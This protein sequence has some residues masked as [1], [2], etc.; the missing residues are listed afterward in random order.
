MING[1]TILMAVTLSGVFLMTNRAVAQ[2]LTKWE[3]LSANEEQETAKFVQLL[4]GQ[5]EHDYV[6]KDKIV[7]RNAHPRGIAC[8]AATFTIA[9]PNDSPHLGVFK[10]PG[11]TY[12]AIIRFSSTLGPAGDHVGDAR[13]MSIKLFDV[14]GTKLLTDQPHANTQ[15]FTQIDTPAFF[16]VNTHDFAGV[17]RLKSEPKSIVSFLLESPIVH[18]LELKQLHDLT[19][20]NANNGKS[21]A[22]TTFFSQVPYRYTDGGEIDHAIKF[23]TR[24]CGSPTHLALN[25]TDTE[26]RDDLQDRLKQGPLCYEFGLQFFKEGSGLKIEDGT[27]VWKESV[28]PFITYAKI[29]IP[30]QN[31]KTDAKLK[32]CENLSFQPWHTTTTHQP[33][34]NINRSRRVIY[35]AISAFRHK[36]NNQQDLYPEPVSRA[37]FDALTDPT[38]TAWNSVTVPKGSH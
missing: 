21:L 8:V 30:Q 10:N 7:F 27:N 18:A 20:G 6:A 2:Q 17:I 23:S 11:Q 1:Q 25:G 37:A 4:I 29:A 14:P 31:F 35:E 15:D 26:L 19:A 38:Y 12:D 36:S 13:G 33:L 24:P 32:Y 28:T 5:L 16:T 9:G 3:T 22:E 34:G